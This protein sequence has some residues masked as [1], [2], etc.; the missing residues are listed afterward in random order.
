[1]EP[2]YL[3][4][5]V[6]RAPGR[7]AADAHAG[8]CSNYRRAHRLQGRPEGPLA[9]GRRISSEAQTSEFSENSEVSVKLWDS[10]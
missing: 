7:G 3:C 9:R 8:G 2:V 4:P 6:A 10:C 5:P 1:M